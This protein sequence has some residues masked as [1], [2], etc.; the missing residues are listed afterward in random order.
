MR[1]HVV[2]L[3]YGDDEPVADRVDRAS[4]VVR[5]QRGADL[6]VLPELWAH[7]AF[8]YRTWAE[9][10][11]TL[12]GPSVTAL[13]EA[14]RDIGASV[15]AGSIVERSPGPEGKNLWNTSVVLDGDGAVV[16]TY[17]K[18]HRFGFGKGEPALM[19]AG[20]SIVTCRLPLSEDRPGQGCVT[21]GLAT[22]YDLRFPEMFRLLLDAGARLIV[23]PAAWPEARVGHWNLLGRAR[24][25]E[26]Q[27][28]V[29][30]CNTAGTHA[31]VRMGG[32]SQ[33]VAPDGEVLA[34]AERAEDVLAVDVDVAQVDAYRASFPVLADRRL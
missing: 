21:T 27:C 23:V 12:D 34:E 28:V 2:Q 18:I 3:G 14:A 6:V 19:E 33:V 17:R 7:G 4:A 29:V 9:R 1:I 5:E 24:A 16:A 15:H 20:T 11:E 8:A 10:A 22:C 26:N 31:G 13:A 30:Q 32:C 25:V